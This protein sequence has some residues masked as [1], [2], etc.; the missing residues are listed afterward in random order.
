MVI[1]DANERDHAMIRAI[2]NAAFDE[3]RF[4]E[5]DIIEGVRAEGRVLVELVADDDAQ[6]VGHVLFSRMRT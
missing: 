5:A 3:S 4:H 6:V 2:T 1:R